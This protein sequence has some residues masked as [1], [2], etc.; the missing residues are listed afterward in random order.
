VI[1]L[2]EISVDCGHDYDKWDFV[3]CDA[4]SVMLYLLVAYL[5]DLPFDQIIGRPITE[6]NTKNLVLYES[7]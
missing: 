2:F 6:D 5:L 3:E 7:L 4:C 1:N